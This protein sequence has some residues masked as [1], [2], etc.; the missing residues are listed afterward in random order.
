MAEGMSPPGYRWDCRHTQSSS[1]PACCVEMLSSRVLCPMR[2]S[3]W[4]DQFEDSA[5]MVQP[6][7]VF[8]PVSPS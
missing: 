1:D 6:N 4:T 5:V 8:E 3:Q 7:G 2:H